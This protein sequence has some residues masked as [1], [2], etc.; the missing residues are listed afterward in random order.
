[1]S[2]GLVGPLTLTCDSVIFHSLNWTVHAIG[3]LVGVGGVRPLVELDDHTQACRPFFPRVSQRCSCSVG[4]RTVAVSPKS[5]RS[6]SSTQRMLRD[7]NCL[8][9]SVSISVQIRVRSPLFSGNQDT[10]GRLR[11]RVHS[12]RSSDSI[13][14]FRNIVVLS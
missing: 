5:R 4:F 13:C 8:A 6:L 9:Q 2:A 12:P 7:T 11:C 14:D 10:W 3:V 1:M